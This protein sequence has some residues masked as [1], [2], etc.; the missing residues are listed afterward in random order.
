MKR[1]VAACSAL[2]VALS[3]ASA[4][5]PLPTDKTLFDTVRPDVI[6][7]IKKHPTGADMVVVDYVQ[8]NY[9]PELARAQIDDLGKRLGVPARGLKLE[10]NQIAA[11]GSNLTFLKCS[12]AINGLL[13]RDEGKVGLQPLV[14]AFT[15]ANA[16][17]QIKGLSVILDAESATS[18]NVR[19]FKSDA[20]EVQGIQIEKPPGVEYRISIKATEPDKIFIPSWSG[21]KEPEKPVSPPKPA[22]DWSLY[23]MIIIAAAAVGALVYSFLLR[24]P[25][26]RPS[27]GSQK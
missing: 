15:G 7:T 4:Q 17:H 26:E 20:V 8:E 22:T 19:S 18:R 27:A 3:T 24:Q 1:F 9:P 25:K 13:N 16:G 2:L 11:G 5:T 21:E 6:V 14:Q 10:A 23:L 12:F